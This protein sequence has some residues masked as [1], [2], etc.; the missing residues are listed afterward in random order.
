[1]LEFK[2]NYVLRVSDFDCYDRL[3][4]SAVL[5]LFQDVAGQHADEIGVGYNDLIKKDI[6]WVLLR[7]KFDVV[8]N[9][10]LYSEVTAVT[11]PHERGRGDF[12][13]DYLITSKDGEVLVKGSSKWC[14]CNFV[15]R[16][17]LFGNEVQYN[18]TEYVDRKVYP[19]GIK[20][21]KDFPE[22]NCE[23]YEGRSQFGDL[24]HNGHVNNI[25]YADYILNA[26]D[27]EKNE[28]IKSVEIDYIHEMQARSEF[29]IFYF[30]K[31]GK[32]SLKCLSE[33]KEIF[34]AE[35]ETETK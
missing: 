34:R 25:K 19:D 17:I 32:Y 26:L 28:E 18:D 12:D 29:K 6:I 1:M 22:E 14:V 4:P 33:G 35:V 9:P 15:T 23:V 8:K 24:D 20:K 16:R 27:L 13:R 21:I 3:R 11:W 31:E 10:E 30:K 2:K 7:N 5:D